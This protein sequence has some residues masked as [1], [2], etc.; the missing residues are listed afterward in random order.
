MLNE[1]HLC[2]QVTGKSMF[3]KPKAMQTQSELELLRSWT[4]YKLRSTRNAYYF[5]QVTGESM[6]SKPKAMQT[7]SELELLS[8]C[9]EY[10]LSSR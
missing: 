6:F 5:C 8:G 7:K 1:K 2:N 10:K 9:T 4:E 3:S